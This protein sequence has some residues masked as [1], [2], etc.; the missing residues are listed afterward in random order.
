MQTD[1]S[2]VLLIVRYIG[3]KSGTA[4]AAQCFMEKNV[5]QPGI[6]LSVG[7]SKLGTVVRV[8]HVLA[9]DILGLDKTRTVR[10]LMVGGRKRSAEVSG[11][12]RGRAGRPPRERMAG[13]KVR[14]PDRK[15]WLRWTS[16]PSDGGA[17][18][19]I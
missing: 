2:R 10:W 19:P 4:D 3:I 7:P 18:A 5:W 16:G 15:S 6:R 12:D 13:Q 11:R 14:S 17:Q 9:V 1:A 8:A